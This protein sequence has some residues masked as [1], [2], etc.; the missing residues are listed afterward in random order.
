MTKAKRTTAL[1][2]AGAVALASG[3]YALGAQAGDGSA[4][5][6]KTAR[7]EA[8]LRPRLRTRPAGPAACDQAST[9]SRTASA[10]TR[11]I[12]APRS[13][14]SR[15]DRKDDFAQRLADAL[16]IDAAKVEQAFENV[17]P[18]R[19]AQ[20][21]RPPA[22]G[23]RRGAREGA[24]PQHREGAR[25]DRG[26]PWASRRPGRPRRRARRERGAAA[27]GLPRRVRQV[28]AAPPRPRRTW[29]RSSASRRRSSRPRS[30]SCTIREE[31]LRDEFA[32]ELADRAE[33]RRR[34]GAR[35][36]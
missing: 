1:A 35:T 21:P 26:A 19:P 24:R 16:G 36:P 22:G 2:L 13:R 25:R 9:T 3:A 6:A 10:S 15:A 29:P 20:A 28:P 33:P 4:E 23:A 12:S 30:R 18:E 5:A 34:E 31:E 32:Q 11:P 17:R 7:G 8:R 14:T 27:R